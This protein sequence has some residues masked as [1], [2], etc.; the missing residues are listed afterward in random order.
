LDWGVLQASATAEG[1]CAL[2]HGGRNFNFPLNLVF[3]TKAPP[4][5]ITSEMTQEPLLFLISTF[6][7]QNFSNVSENCHKKYIKSFPF[8]QKFNR[9]LSKTTL[10]HHHIHN[11]PNHSKISIKIE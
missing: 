3:D 1:Q 9:N 6:Y 8:L 10:V 5:E 2:A 4:P 7:Q 11:K